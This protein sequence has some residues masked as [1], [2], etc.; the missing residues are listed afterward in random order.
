MAQSNSLRP[1]HNTGTRTRFEK[2]SGQETIGALTAR[3]NE[4]MRKHVLASAPLPSDAADG[5]EWLKLQELAEVRSL[6][7]LTATRLNLRSRSEQ[8]LA[9]ALLR[10]ANNGS[11]GL[12]PAAVDP[13]HA[14]PV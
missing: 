12:R 10:R 8:D 14:L 1:N 6:R 11:G 4:V 5:R 2:R 9:G 3:D 7:K 13:T